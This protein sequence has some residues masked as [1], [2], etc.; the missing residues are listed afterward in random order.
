MG[1]P[2]IVFGGLGFI[3]SHLTQRLSE[4]GHEVLIITRRE[5]QH[6]RY[7]NARVITIP[8]ADMNADSFAQV[9]ARSDII[10]NLAGH[11][12]PVLSNLHRLESLEGNCHVQCSFLDGCRIAGNKPRVIFAS[13]R[14][15]YGRSN[16]LPITEKTPISPL[17]FYAAH[18]VCVEHYHMIAAFREEIVHTICR[19]SNAYGSYEGATEGW[20]SHINCMIRDACEGKGLKLFGNG[21]QLRDYVHVSDVVN[22]L[23][24]CSSSSSAINQIF[25]IGSGVSIHLK[26]AVE[27]ITSCTGSSVAEVAWPREQRL[28]ETGDVVFDI[29]KARSLLGYQPEVPFSY[30][31]RELIQ[32]QR[33]N[34]ASRSGN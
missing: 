12:E 29:S 9:I 34:I 14:L 23:L 13:S 2:V 26:D 11:S 16:A 33:K 18:K 4:L 25:N 32:H 5:A 27:V 15:V 7:L 1:K 3:G 10:F 20:S 22:A 24:L 19:I 21:L 30:A 28:A 31:V 6:S 17:G 8:Q